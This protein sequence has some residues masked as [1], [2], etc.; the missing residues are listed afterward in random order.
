MTAL[1][2]GVASAFLLAALA[3]SWSPGAPPRPVPWLLLLA[4]AP[5]L[6]GWG[7]TR[8]RPAT[9]KRARLLGAALVHAAIL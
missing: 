5:P 1:L 6:L 7:R 2:A 8:W 3:E 9:E 4:V